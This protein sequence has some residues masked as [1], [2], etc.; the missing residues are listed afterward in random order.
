MENKRPLILISN[1]DGYHAPGIRKLVEFVK[2]MADVLVCAPEAA[3]SGY[4]CAFSAVDYLRLKPR[5]N[6][7]DTTVY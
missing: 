6:M 4:S 3:R 2:D 5:H 1:D 7:G